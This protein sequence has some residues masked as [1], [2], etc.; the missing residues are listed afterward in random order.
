MSW[1]L[2]TIKARPGIKETTEYIKEAINIVAESGKNSD[3]L[4]PSLEDI[5]ILD[6]GA[7][8]GVYSLYFARKGFDVSALDRKAQI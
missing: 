3:S 7:G 1:Y 4:P 2:L 8:T 5:K 6:I